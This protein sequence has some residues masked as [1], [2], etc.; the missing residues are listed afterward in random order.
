MRFSELLPGMRCVEIIGRPDL[1]DEMAWVFQ[2]NTIE[3][4][5]TRRTHM[6]KVR[7]WFLADADG[8]VKFD[9]GWPET[10]VK[11]DAGAQ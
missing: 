9:F 3:L 8:R 5:K 1:I 4:E 10:K 11:H 2:L 7:A 6:E